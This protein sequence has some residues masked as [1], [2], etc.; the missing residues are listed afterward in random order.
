MKLDIPRPWNAA[1][2]K[3]S[4]TFHLL[5]FHKSQ[6]NLQILEDPC[7]YVSVTCSVWKH[8][9]LQ[10]RKKRS[11]SGFI[12]MSA[13][14]LLITLYHQLE[15][16][17]TS[18]LQGES[19]ILKCHIYTPLPHEKRAPLKTPAWEASTM[20]ARSARHARRNKAAPVACA[21]KR[22]HLNPFKLNVIVTRDICFVLLKGCMRYQPDKA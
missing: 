13:W 11:R 10:E 16:V 14:K 15:N 18:N 5:C 22:N 9:E 6:N 12:L 7:F 19:P 1:C 2:W 20:R 3:F 21:S 4:R 17:T 8:L